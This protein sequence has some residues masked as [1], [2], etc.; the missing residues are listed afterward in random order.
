MYY[1]LFP[2]PPSSGRSFANT[3][4][5][6][7]GGSRPTSWP[8]WAI[9]SVNQVEYEYNGG[10]KVRCEHQEPDSEVDANTLYVQYDYESSRPSGEGRVRARI[11]P[12]TFGSTR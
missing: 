6:R 11:R 4:S 10:S 7:R 3:H 1:T 12:S 5:T 2:S 8:A 9:P